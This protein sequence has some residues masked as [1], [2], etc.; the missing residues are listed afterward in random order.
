MYLKDKKTG[1]VENFDEK[2]LKTFEALRKRSKMEKK[3]TQDVESL[4]NELINIKKMFEQVVE[5]VKNV[6][7]NS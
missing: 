7:T 3:L 6:N 5:R 2:E 1:F 4:Q